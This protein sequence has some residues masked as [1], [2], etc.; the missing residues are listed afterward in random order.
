MA[1]RKP[2]RTGPGGDSDQLTR[3]LI[4]TTALRLVDAEGMDT[5]TM[6]ALADA[7]DV[8]PTAVYWH[9]GSKSNLATLIAEQVFN[10]LV[11]SDD[12]QLA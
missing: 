5:L 12:N 9:V 7:L 10:E 2:R 6:R 8:Y 1:G 11:L 4:V 3:E